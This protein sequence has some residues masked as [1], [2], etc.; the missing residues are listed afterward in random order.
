M[1]RTTLIF[2]STLLFMPGFLLAQLASRYYNLDQPADI[3]HLPSSLR[4]ISGLGYAKNTNHLLAVNDELGLVFFLIPENGQILKKERFGVN[5]DYEGVCHSGSDIYVI[6]SRGTIHVLTSGNTT[7]RSRILKTRLN[8]WTNIEGICFLPGSNSLLL[9]GKGRPQDRNK[10][11][12]RKDKY[13]YSYDLSENQLRE[14]PYLRIRPADLETFYLRQKKDK[15]SLSR[16][17][18]KRLESFSPSGLAIHP[19]T[20]D[21]YIVSARGQS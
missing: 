3:F 6:S 8:S 9:A 21:L 10:A 18:K 19:E 11:V 5:G 15:K 12:D 14:E 1:N 2:L 4:E 16:S 17:E 20:E 13:L 7:P